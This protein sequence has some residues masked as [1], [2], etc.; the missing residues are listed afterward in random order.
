M[1][2]VV[3]PPIMRQGCA[4]VLAEVKPQGSLEQAR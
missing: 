4:A 3:C 2:L 1:A